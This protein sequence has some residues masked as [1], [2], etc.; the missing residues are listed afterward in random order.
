MYLCIIAECGKLRKKLCDYINHEIF[1]EMC[2]NL[3]DKYSP[4]IIS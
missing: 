2:L 4:F 1:T 3:N